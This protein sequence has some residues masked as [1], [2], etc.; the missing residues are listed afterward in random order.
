MQ[1]KSKQKK[2]SA[3]TTIIALVCIIVYI[4]ALVYAGIQIYVGIDENRILAE[5]EFFDLTDRAAAAAALGFMN[6]PFRAAI[7]DGIADSR[8]IE[9]VIISG[10]G[11]EYAFERERGNV[12]TYINNS[13]RFKFR[14]D[15]DRNTLNMPLRIEGL[16]NVNI[17]AAASRIDYGMVVEILKKTLLAVLLSLI[18]A[19]I[20]LLLEALPVKSRVRQAYAGISEPAGQ[21]DSGPG[22]SPFSGAGT[23][24]G[25][26]TASPEDEVPGPEAPKAAYR[27]PEPRTEQGAGQ[28]AREQA[29]VENEAGPRGLFTPNGNIGWEDYTRERLDA[30]LHRCASFE[31][32]L[33]FIV[34][35]FKNPAKIDGGFYRQFADDAVNFFT[36]RDLIFEKGRR[37]ISIIYPNIDLETG[38]AK[39]EEFHNRVLSKYSAAF[40][41]KTDLCIGL[42]SRSGRL[43]DADRI[44]FEAV[45]ALGKALTDPVSHIVAFKS[46]PE[47][48]R[49]FIRKSGS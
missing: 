42:S 32:D 24:A 34:M 26:K 46:D 12:V 44:M 38:F 10:P 20:T 8:T 35:E 1:H 39:S 37:G 27:T 45:E 13:P 25:P 49:D 9:G 41:A 6:D 29:P 31:Q 15:L 36:L 47:K 2:S 5:R 11:G 33:V 16:R 40:T 4:A 23:G 48:Y 19:F 21:D 28:A 30:E 17:Q 3:L 14:P 22:F 43:I 7:E 18:F